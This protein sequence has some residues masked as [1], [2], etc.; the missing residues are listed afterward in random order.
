MP[1]LRFLMTVAAVAAFAAPPVHAFWWRYGSWQGARDACR[2]WRRQYGNYEVYNKYYEQWQKQDIAE[3][4][5]ST[6]QMIGWIRP[7]EE[8]SRWPGGYGSM[9]SKK[10]GKRF[11]Y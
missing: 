6:G 11:R 2:E 3:C 10:V 7:V 1:K 9:P 4:E 5:R 8:N